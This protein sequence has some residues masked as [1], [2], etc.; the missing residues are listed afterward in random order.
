MLRQRSKIGK[1]A[2]GAVYSTQLT[3]IN[4][5]V[6]IKRAPVITHQLYLHREIFEGIDMTYWRNDG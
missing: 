3:A 6:H 1:H 2:R 4:H 5:R